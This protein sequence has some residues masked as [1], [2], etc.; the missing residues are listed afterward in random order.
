MKTYLTSLIRRYIVTGAAGT[1]VHF[2]L[3][4][5][6]AHAFGALLAS[7]IGATAGAVVNYLLL[8]GWVFSDRTARPINYVAMCLLS[9]AFNMLLMAAVSSFGVGALP[10]QI[11]SS[12]LVMIVNFAVSQKWVFK[13]ETTGCK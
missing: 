7:T 9:I 13:Y 11:F 3:L 12:G 10:A 8:K 6:L 4:L 2:A 5:L 1:A